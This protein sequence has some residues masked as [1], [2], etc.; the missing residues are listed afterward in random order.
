[1]FCG[2]GPACD[3]RGLPGP[4]VGADAGPAAELTE[5]HFHDLRHTGNDLTAATGATLREMMDRMGH[6][7]PR[8]ALVYMHGHDDRQ[9]EIADSLNK[10]AQSELSRNGQ[11][12]ERGTRR[13]PIG[14][15]T[16]TEAPRCLVITRT[17]SRETRPELVGWVV[18]LR[19]LEPR[20][21]SLSG[22][23]CSPFGSA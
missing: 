13:K 18:G 23:R 21:S 14:H 8:A 16:G 20:T 3:G 2:C 9:R 1:G 15:A 4:E 11:W 22:C 17:G 12:A 19:G 7:S 5:L 10:L 6:S